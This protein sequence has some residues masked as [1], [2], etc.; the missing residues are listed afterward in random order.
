MCSIKTSINI[1]AKNKTGIII[2]VYSWHF[3]TQLIIISQTY[4]QSCLSILSTLLHAGQ[5]IQTIFTVRIVVYSE[6]PEYR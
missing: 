1:K 2:K 6:A 4:E 5:N 3:K